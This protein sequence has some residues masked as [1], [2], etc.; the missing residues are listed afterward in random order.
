MIRD[1][2]RIVG[3]RM[4]WM[5]VLS[6]LQVQGLQARAQQPENA[7]L[8]KLQQEQRQLSSRFTDSLLK[9]AEFCDEKQFVEPATRIRGL[10]KPVDARLLVSHQLPAAVR[11]EISTGLPADQRH[12]QVQ[13]RYLQTKYARD[14]YMLSR[15]VLHNRFPSYAL[16]LVREV[17]F[18]DPDHKQARDL[19]GYVRYGD[20]WVTPFEKVRLSASPKQVWHEQYGWIPEVYLKRYEQGQRRYRKRWLGAA[21]EAE[22]RSDFRNAWQV[23]TGHF[24]V[25]TN[26]SLEQGVKVASAL[27]DFRRF[28]FQTFVAYF[29]TPRQI[30]QIFSGKKSR[31]RRAPR[32]HEVHYFRT[33]EE[34]NERLAAV[35]PQI[36]ITNGLYYTPDRTSYFFYN[37]SAERPFDTLYHE[38][39]HQFLYENLVSERAIAEHANFWIVEGIAC[40]MESFRPDGDGFSVGDP[41]HI[42]F[43]AARHRLLHDKYYVPLE[44]FSARG[45]KI[46]Q[47]DLANISKNYSQASGLAHFFMHYENGRYRDALVTHLREIYRIRRTKRVEVPGLDALT[48]VGFDDLDRQYIAYMKRM[49][50]EFD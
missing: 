41:Q 23:R 24:L 48:G 50:D 45:L 20:L 31:T 28:F 49:Q 16:D 19:L 17:A 46:F 39:T 33:R 13:L 4:L 32:P 38:A 43:R 8:L 18:H 22:I 26:H 7:R 10:A 12:W 2:D 30:Q 11:E 44:E 3:R 42:R 15:S 47:S 40:Y 29:N 21:Q 36:A 25:K 35:I 6:L 27:E 37:P 5:L 34:Y 1:S 14:I 9:L